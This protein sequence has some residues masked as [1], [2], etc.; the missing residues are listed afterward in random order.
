MMANLGKATGYCKGK[1]IYAHAISPWDIRLTVLSAGLSAAGAG[2]SIAMED[3]SGLPASFMCSD[4]DPF[5]SA[6]MAGAWKLP[7]IYLENNGWVHANT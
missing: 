4:Q 1:R 6:N 2:L 3:G 7:V 5:R